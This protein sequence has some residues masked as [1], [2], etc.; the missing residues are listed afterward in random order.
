[1]QGTVKWFDP[2][3]RFGFITPSE[4]GK[5]VFVHADEVLNPSKSLDEGGRV[6][7]EVIQTDKG[8]QAKDVRIAD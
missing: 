1:M 2:V 8:P 7:F 5:D 3:K 4:G 6:E